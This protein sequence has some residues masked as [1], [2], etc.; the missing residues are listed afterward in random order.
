MSSTYPI[1]KI[2]ATTV[3]EILPVFINKGIFS[4]YDDLPERADLLRERMDDL[5]QGELT[6][7]QER[8]YLTQISEYKTDDYVV[9]DYGNYLIAF[10]LNAY[11]G[12]L[13]ND[14]QRV[15]LNQR[16]HK[17][18]MIILSEVYS[19]KKW[20]GLVI[21][22]QKIVE[23]LGYSSRDKH[24]Y[25]DISDV[26]YSLRWLDYKIIEYK[27]KVKI[28]ED[29]KTT[30]NFIYNLS[31]DAKSYTL[32]INKLFV[33]SIVYVLTGDKTSLPN[34]A[35]KRGYFTYPTSLLPMSKDYSQGAYLLTN[36]LMAEK[37]NYK[38]KTTD[39]KVIA[40]K[41][42]KLMEVMK[43][44]YNRDDKNYQSFLNS[45]EEAQIIDRVDPDI[46]TLRTLKPSRIQDQVVHLYVK[47]NIKQLD[48]EIKS[49]H[50]V[51]K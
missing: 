6:F 19:Q 5:G 26:M 34:G 18:A 48:E 4:N 50:W 15:R 23:C 38:L 37:G 33:G 41:I 22:K 12:N 1:V 28:R 35:F 20:E 21:P 30:G 3:K 45:L 47:K 36:F 42:P 44:N 10:T 49:I 2:D 46:S 17:I 7:E 24:I 25:R 13:N 40:Y 8:E 29:K 27:T 43:L 14:L 16:G 9:R 11:Q 51:T 31:E 32:W 39:H